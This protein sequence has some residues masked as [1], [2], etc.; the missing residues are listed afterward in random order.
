MDFSKINT[1]SLRA[2]L[3]L[4]ERKETLLAELEKLE[5]ELL[6]HFNGNAK[7][8]SGQTVKASKKEKKVKIANPLQE[9]HRAPRGEMKQQVLKA[10]AEAGP[11]GIKVPELAKK[12]GAKNANVHVWL[13]SS[14]KKLPEIE[15]VGAGI[16][17]IRAQG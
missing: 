12:I 7:L 6:A 13:S 2:I 15:R 9:R 11:E 17:R 8:L 1:T 5:K 16:F 10:L 3:K 14:G 4:S